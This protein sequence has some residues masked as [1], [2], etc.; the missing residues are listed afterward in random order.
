[1]LA[2]AMVCGLLTSTAPVLT[3]AASA[4]PAELRAAIRHDL[5]MSAAEYLRSAA[6][7]TGRTYAPTSGND[8]RGGDPMLLSAGTCSAGFTAV[9][10]N[11]IG[12]VLT[13]GH[14]GRVGGPFRIGGGM[15]GVPDQVRFDDL[16]S[17]GQGDDYATLQVT[18]PNVRLHPEVSNYQGGAVP[19]TGLAAPA[20]GMPVCKS[21]AG[22]RWTCGV[23]TAVDVVMKGDVAAQPGVGTRIQRVFTHTACSES[24]DSGGAVLSGTKAV[25]ITEG[26]FPG[27]DGHCPSAHGG[28]NTSLAEPL[29]SDVLPD[30]GGKLFLL[31]TTGDVD[32]DGVPDTVELAGDPTAMRDTNHNGIAAFRDPDEPKPR[33]AAPVPTT[34]HA[35]TT[36]AGAQLGAAGSAGSPYAMSESASQPL[37]ARS[38]DGPDTLDFI[39]WPAA[40]FLVLAFFA[41]TVSRRQPG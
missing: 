36:G 9:D 32:G 34:T 29:V 35:T 16:N 5:G 38:L 25:G 22:T 6:T 11:G 33:V 2:V 28:T 3:S 4:L 1:M 39:L 23:I 13:A 27:Q 21:G 14:C 20:V 17:G 37:A 15:L 7:F 26:G 24:G 18:N 19:V 12:R 8:L 40:L 30:F 10:A 41:V 31:T